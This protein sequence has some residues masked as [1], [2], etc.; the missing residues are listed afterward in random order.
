MR[1]LKRLL[2]TKETN[3]VGSF[4]LRGEGIELLIKKGAV[5]INCDEVGNVVGLIVENGEEDV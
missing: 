1:E 5:N 2:K 3:I 4:M